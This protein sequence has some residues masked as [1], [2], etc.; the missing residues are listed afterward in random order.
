MSPPRK[1]VL[2]AN[3]LVRAVFGKRVYGLF[4]KLEDRRTQAAY[5]LSGGE[6]QM[7][8]IGR[9]LMSNP[10]LLMCETKGVYLDTYQFENLN[11]FTL[12]AQRRKIEVPA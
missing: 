3:I 12:M 11:H 1:L 2:D 9:A 4:P 10:K 7:V 6:Q 5:T 8:A